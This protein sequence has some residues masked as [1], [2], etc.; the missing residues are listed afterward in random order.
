[1]AEHRI[2]A[3][4]RF[5]AL[6]CASVVWAPFALIRTAIFYLIRID[7]RVTKTRVQISILTYVSNKRLA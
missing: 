5:D 4:R 1:M 2:A 6:L 3:F 7:R